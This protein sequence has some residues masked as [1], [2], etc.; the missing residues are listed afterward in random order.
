M[1]DDVID[2][3]EA[4]TKEPWQGDS[5]DDY[6]RNIDLAREVAFEAN[7]SEDVVKWRLWSWKSD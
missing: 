3:L 1:D 7:T 5:V 4:L 2:A 6:T